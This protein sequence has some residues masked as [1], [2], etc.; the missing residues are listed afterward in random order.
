MAASLI[1]T[2][3]LP[4]KNMI[5]ETGSYVVFEKEYICNNYG[6]EGW[7]PRQSNLIQLSQTLDVPH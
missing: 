4:I 6:Q 7:S 1:S 3:G 2:S 5:R